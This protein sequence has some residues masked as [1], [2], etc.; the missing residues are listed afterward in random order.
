[1]RR[2]SL[3]LTLSAFATL[4]ATMAGCSPAA[5]SDGASESQIKGAGSS[6]ATY[7]EAVL[8][9]AHNKNDEKNTWKC[10]GT[11]I[12]PSVVLTSGICAGSHTSWTVTAPYAKKQTTTSTSSA[13]YR[14][15][16]NSKGHTDIKAHNIGLIFLDDPI[17]LTAY[18]VLAKT[19]IGTGDRAIAVGRSRDN[20][21]S[22]TELFTSDP[23]TLRAST[24]V[25]FPF[26]YSS[27]HVVDAGDS[28]GAQLLV[29]S[30]PH[31]IVSV[32]SKIVGADDTFSRVDLPD[33]AEWIRQEVE[34]HGGYATNMDAG[35]DAA[36]RITEDAGAADAASAADAR[37]STDAA[38]A[39]AAPGASA[40]DLGRCA[41]DVD[42]NKGKY[43]TNWICGD[44][45]T[46]A[47]WCVKGCH[48][49]LD[50]PGIQ[51]CD[52]TTD[53]SH[54]DCR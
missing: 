32:T 40:G 24:A 29:G 26:D 18:P 33:V 35:T 38:T 16:F 19:P 43:L 9:D 39:D 28:G 54:W 49:D 11:V 52:K 53:P 14:W 10:S 41:A 47:G 51:L 46:T 48:N 45:G 27:A 36:K 8:I 7:P 3:N 4:I 42:C 15:S 34:G 22:D 21:V 44:T 20:K 2:R 12:A 30:K 31:V 5:D 50:C 25:D 6:G 1:M 37:D 13:A 17:T 23:L